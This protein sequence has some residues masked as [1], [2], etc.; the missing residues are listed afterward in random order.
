MANPYFVSSGIPSNA[1][2]ALSGVARSEFA[3][4]AEGFNKVGGFSPAN[5][6]VSIGASSWSLTDSYVVSD[7]AASPLLPTVR[8]ST[9]GDLAVTYFTQ[10]GSYLQ[11]GPFVMVEF[12]LSGLL[13]YT[14]ASGA[15]AVRL[16][17]TPEVSAL[18]GGNLGPQSCRVT[19]SSGFSADWDYVSAIFSVI[20]GTK[21]LIFLSQDMNGT[22]TT[23]TNPHMG[24]GTT[25][26]VTGTFAYVKA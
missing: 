20:D 13:S 4:V 18:W 9:A 22:R 2:P 25:F 6:I 14:T 5:T 3:R 16:Q 10:G 23:I 8:F 19:N 7:P 12:S 24:S 15:F 26:T 21:M 11:I 1:S 17:G